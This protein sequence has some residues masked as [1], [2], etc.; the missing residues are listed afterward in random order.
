[1]TKQTK[2]SDMNIATCT[3]FA[4]ASSQV[5]AETRDTGCDGQPRI[6]AVDGG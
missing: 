2:M 5:G 1:M 6:Q 3:E 4:V